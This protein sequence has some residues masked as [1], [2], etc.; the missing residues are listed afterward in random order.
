MYN[1]N[2]LP[3]SD[4]E[5]RQK[6]KGKGETGQD[7]VQ[8]TVV[9][10]IKVNTEDQRRPGLSREERIDFYPQ[11]SQQQGVREEKE[12]GERRHKGRGYTESQRKD[13]GKK[14]RKQGRRGRG[15][16]PV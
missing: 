15:R 2:I 4:I 14:G 7:K 11:W 9:A 6:I 3:L 13:A 12:E 1:P 16:M 8:L 5:K 10:E